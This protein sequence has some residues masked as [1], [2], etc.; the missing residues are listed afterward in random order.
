VLWRFAKEL[1]SGSAVLVAALVAADSSLLSVSFITHYGG[2]VDPLSV[3]FLYAGSYTTANK[4][5]E[6][7]AN[8]NY[9][10][11]SNGSTPYHKAAR[12]LNLPVLELLQQWGANV[13]ATTKSGWL[14]LHNAVLEYFIRHTS[15]AGDQLQDVSTRQRDL[16][17][18]Q[19]IAESYVHAVAVVDV[20]TV[21]CPRKPGRHF[22]DEMQQFTKAVLQQALSERASRSSAAAAAAAVTAATAP[23]AAT[24]ATAAA[25]SN[26]PLAARSAVNADVRGGGSSQQSPQLIGATASAT[27]TNYSATGTDHSTAAA[28]DNDDILPLWLLELPSSVAQSSNN[29]HTQQQSDD[30]C[31]RELFPEVFGRN[32]MPDSMQSTS[33]S[34]SSSSSTVGSK[35][36]YPEGSADSCL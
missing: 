5:L 18:V 28:D 32:A 30:E 15:A 16:A 2:D 36:P 24:A 20:E 26:G 8:I 17:A 12:Q 11:N 33:S 3:A 22:T 14:G 9:A 6:C 7:G 21:M 27:G 31:L 35:R 19:L 13:T 1:L 29:L 4:L 10:S 34:S 25:G 23:T